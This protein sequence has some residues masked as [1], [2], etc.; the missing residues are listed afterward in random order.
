MPDHWV[1][2]KEK[3][4]SILPQSWQGDEAA[5]L[6]MGNSIPC[7][8]SHLWGAIWAPSQ[9]LGSRGAPELLLSCRESRKVMSLSLE[10]KEPDSHPT[11]AQPAWPTDET[12]GFPRQRPGSR[13]GS[14]AAAHRGLSGRLWDPAAVVPMEPGQLMAAR[15]DR[16]LQLV[17]SLKQQTQSQRVSLGVEEVR[18]HCRQVRHYALSC[19]GTRGVSVAAGPPL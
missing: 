2:R 8:P 4:T 19:R 5:M 10:T 1:R 6:L 15:Q 14:E 11:G 16:R 9:E 13:G 17:V 12:L 7:I 3:A 18:E